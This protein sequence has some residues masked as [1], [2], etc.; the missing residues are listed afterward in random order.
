MLEFDENERFGDMNE[1]FIERVMPVVECSTGVPDQ[2][3]LH[4]SIIIT[5]TFPHWDT[6]G[7]DWNSQASISSFID[8]NIKLDFSEYPD[9]YIFN[10]TIDPITAYIT[11]VAA[12][13]DTD[14]DGTINT[15]FTGL[16]CLE[17]QINDALLNTSTGIVAEY[18]RKVKINLKLVAEVRKTLMANR[19]LCEDFL[20]LNAVKVEEI[21]ICG[22]ID[23]AND[24]NIEEVLANIYHEVGKFLSPTVFFHTITEMVEKGK[25]M[26]EIFEG[27]RLKH[28]FID[29]AELKKAEARQTIH[30]SDIYQIIM[31]VPG[32]IAVKNLQIANFPE[33]TDENIPSVSVKWCLD[34]AFEKNFVPRL[35]TERSNLTFFKE[36]LPFQADEVKV[37][38][39]LDELKNLDPPQRLENPVLDLPVPQ[40]EFKELETYTSAQEE[41]P[42]V[43]GIGTAGLPDS[44][45]TVRKAQAHQLKGFMMFFD[46]LLA[47]YLS[48]LAHVKDLF[49][50]NEARGNDGNFIIDR[51]Y[52]TQTLFN[53]VPDAASLYVHPQPVHID[54][55]NLI[56]EDENLFESRRNHFLD[57]LL[58]R[59]AESF[60]DY[61]LLAYNI[62]GPKAPEELIEDKLRF[63]NSYP[64]ISYGRAGGF[65]YADTCK[66]W[67]VDN[68]SGLEKRASLLAGIDP[69]KPSDLVFFPIFIEINDTLGIAPYTFMVKD[70]SNN[71]VM[72]STRNYDTIDDVFVGTEEAIIA[73]LFPENYFIFDVNFPNVPIDPTNP[74]SATTFFYKVYCDGSPIARSKTGNT[75]ATVALAFANAGLAFQTFQYEYERLPSSNRKDLDCAL[76]D[77]V[78]TS[79]STVTTPGCPL[80]AQID[81]TITNDA[82]DDN[83]LAD[84]LFKYSVR[85]TAKPDEDNAAL[86]TRAGEEA[87]DLLLDFFLIA[88]NRANYRTEVIG[89]DYVFSVFDECKETIGSSVETDFNANLAFFIKND[90]GQVIVIDQ[91]GN[92]LG[93]N[94]ITASSSLNENINITLTNPVTLTGGKITKT[95]TLPILAGDFDTGRRKFIV[96]EDLRG[97]VKTGE[98]LSVTIGINTADYT[99]AKVSV[100]DFALG[101]YRTEIMLKES[102]IALSTDIGSI[103]HT[104]EIPIL[105]VTNPTTLLL[106]GG[107]AEIAIDEFVD[108]IKTR[109]MSHE[110]LHLVEHILLRPTNKS[111]KVFETAVAQTLSTPG[112]LTDSLSPQGDIYFVKTVNITAVDLVTKTFTVSGDV[113]TEIQTLQRILVSGSFSGLNDRSF[114][115][116]SFAL[117]GSDTDIKVIESISDN[118]SP[119]G[120]I[121]FTKKVAIVNVVS[122]SNLIVVAGTSSAAELTLGDVIILTGSQNNKNDTRYTIGATAINAGNTEITIDKFENDHKDKFLIINEVSGCEDCRYED[123]YSFI[124]SVILPHWRGRFSNQAFRKF[125]ERTLRLEAPAHVVLNICWI[126]CEQMKE[127]EQSYKSWLFQHARKDKDA[128]ATTDTLNKLIDTLQKLRSVYPKGTLHDC[129]VDTQIRNSVILNQTQLGNI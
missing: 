92:S 29:D 71:D 57:H 79:I 80:A 121:S 94:P 35:V 19:N 111:I 100:I 85:I 91:N 64:E 101:A 73:G 72:E 99:V 96:N 61:A 112:T 43:Y 56:A 127:F 12:G 16:A 49:S 115:I 27:P 45:S 81:Y 106:T 63:L 39:L 51:T 84:Q 116:Q 9:N 66:L 118:T 78:S 8:R 18:Q 31:D 26:D 123:P 119:F 83:V 113:T 76:E 109:F 105:A 86:I 126:N 87:H 62:D 69:F 88:V 114:T 5:A 122:A 129:E 2:V 48:Q 110:G 25:T 103:T 20:N 3:L 10:Y 40:G 117:S 108:F 13:I 125:F 50:L 59:F 55:L 60:A 104:A 97:L 44:A 7:V 28:G 36:F 67:S 70:F 128:I 6:L 102:F 22:D 30:V 52:F 46:Q 11:I 24:A 75:F 93:V 82:T 21:G 89:T 95:F 38:V 98:I 17:S 124:V 58:A 120:N 42:L 68:V 41:F 32:V 23:V 74:P 1:N 90:P 34:L 33:Q 4:K 37:L 15:P 107:V 14:R 54:N 65:D 47:D 77:N 53:I